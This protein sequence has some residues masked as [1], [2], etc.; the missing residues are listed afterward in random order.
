MTTTITITTASAAIAEHVYIAMHSSMNNVEL[1][2]VRC[3]AVAAT[4]V[5]STSVEGATLSSICILTA[6]WNCSSTVHCGC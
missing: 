1:Q 6:L 5:T 2:C 3:N 4:T